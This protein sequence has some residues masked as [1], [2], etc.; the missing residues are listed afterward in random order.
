M[1]GDLQSGRRAA[2]R[3]AGVFLLAI[4]G[5]VLARKFLLAALG[6]R[7]T[8]VTFYPAVVICGLY[9]GWLTGVL[10]AGTSC[11]IA[12]YAWPLI[13]DQPFIE[14]H[15]DWLGMFAFLC[16]SV[17]ISAMAEAAR[18]ARSRAAEA[19]EQAEAANR[20]KSVFL[21]NMSHELR[22][23][24]NAILGFSRLLRDDETV[25]PED[26]QT[27]DIITQSGEHL[28]TI[29]N[30]VLDLAKI[31]SGRVVLERAAF[32]VRGTLRDVARLMGERAEAKGLTLTLTIADDVPPAVVGDQS[33][34]RQ[35]VLNLVA[36]AVKFTAQG[37]V[38]LR[39][40]SRFVG[41]TARTTLVIEVEDSGRG[42]AAGDQER[43]FH[44]FVRVGDE[45][46]QGGT[47]LGLSIAR[48][49]I[50]AMGG[51]I[52]VR[53]APGEGATFLVEL[54]MEA[55]E[56]PSGVPAGIGQP[57]VWRLADGQPE[58]R[59][60]IVED[61]AVNAL[62]MRRLLERTGFR[63][64]VAENG[65]MGVA[66]FRTWQPHFILMDWRMPVMDGGEATRRI[67]GLDGGRNVKIVALAA[68]V[69]LA[70]RR[71]PSAPGVDDFVSKPFK[72]DEIIECMAR[73]LSLRFVSDGPPLEAAGPTAD[74]D[75]SALRALPASVREALSTAVV[76]LDAVRIGAAIGRV[77]D[78]N[79]AL[80]AALDQRACRLQYTQML[81]A[82]QLGR[83]GGAKDEA[84]RA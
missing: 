24:L 1:S 12:L 67:R 84:P 82:L 54:P 48:R 14:D 42:I 59:V 23:P 75:R 47:G 53:S 19:Q 56:V 52:G 2:L 8:W 6:T 4:A 83:L 65:E 15:A 11:L 16:N 28:L 61:E 43:I 51:V 81:Q 22:S 80:G 41:T 66:M 17:L 76:S 68:S 62:L 39:L 37:G 45:A 74:L 50:E 3:H 21:A 35:I 25:S 73:H 63:V 13:A 31:E 32:D 29:V 71:R 34:L 40:S 7:V 38:T 20:A 55:A 78:L 57:R 27:L 60:L 58:C 10:S 72:F 5:A 64:R 77:S 26:G 9:G 33:K 36:N 79:P 30:D 69:L 49:F 44:P 46:E 70:D 18:R